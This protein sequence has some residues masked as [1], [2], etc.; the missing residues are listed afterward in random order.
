MSSHAL[1]EQTPVRQSKEPGF[2]GEK[3]DAN[4]T[5]TNSQIE[6]NAEDD[7]QHST[8]HPSGNGNQEIVSFDLDDPD[9]PYN[10]SNRKKKFVTFVG[11][12]LVVNSTIGSSIASGATLEFS[13]YFHPDNQEQLVL[14]TSIYLV[15]YVLGPLLFGPLSESYGRKWV[16]VATFVSKSLLNTMGDIG[17]TIAGYLHSLHTCMRIG[18]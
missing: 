18:A 7:L 6:L 9:D 17:L 11:V 12:A 14:P 1:N 2:E 4:V 3:H 15:G 10:W 5:N 16:M 8:S 13:N